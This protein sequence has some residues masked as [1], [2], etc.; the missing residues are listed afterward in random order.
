M[1][2]G[3][4]PRG[5]YFSRERKPSGAVI[6]YYGATWH[7]HGVRKNRKFYFGENCRLT[8]A[9]AFREALDVRQAKEHDFPP[10]WGGHR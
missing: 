7:Q 10:K 6:P 8:E 5:V 3:I 9:Q 2:T 1:K 4:L